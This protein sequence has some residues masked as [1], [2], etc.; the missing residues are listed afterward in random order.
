MVVRHAVK[1]AKVRRDLRIR[2]GC[3]PA[4]VT[5]RTPLRLLCTI[6][7]TLPERI[8]RYEITR[9]LGEGNMGVVFAARDEN[10]ARSVAIKLVQAK[11]SDPNARTR[12]L[13]E[14]RDA[15]AVNH[16]NICHIY[17]VGEHEG[18][19]YVAME[20][21]DGESLADRIG[22]GALAMHRAVEVS[23]A[24]LDALAALHKAGIVHRE[25]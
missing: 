2:A 8:G 19:L 9:K 1:T 10:L 21:L 25:A 17:E 22:R 16:P 24:V 4:P 3:G 20:M 11:T 18:E 7:P 23:A 6:V 14:A 13:R 15:A 5:D 12:L